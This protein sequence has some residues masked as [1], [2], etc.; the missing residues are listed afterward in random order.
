M[1]FLQASL[2]TDLIQSIQPKA[3][4]RVNYEKYDCL[5]RN[6]VSLFFLIG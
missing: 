6:K 2:N 5:Y 1:M 3:V 4:L